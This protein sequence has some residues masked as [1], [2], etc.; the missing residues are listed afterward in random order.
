M[1]SAWPCAPCSAPHQEWGQWGR[2]GVEGAPPETQG[3]AV[4][5]GPVGEVKMVKRSP[6]R[7]WRAGRWDFK[8]LIRAQSPPCPPGPHGHW[9]PVL[10][11]PSS[12]SEAKQPPGHQTGRA[13]G[14]RRHG[15]SRDSGM[16]FSSPVAGGQRHQAAD[17]WVES[18]RKKCV[19]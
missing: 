8:A 17:C 7:D 1:A 10:C 18:L 13:A 4:F 3:T 14:W 12:S 9:L 2:Q 19:K 5:T 15:L 16:D 11:V 6:A